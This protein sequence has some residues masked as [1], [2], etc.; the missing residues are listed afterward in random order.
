MPGPNTIYI[1]NPGLDDQIINKAT[2][3]TIEIYTRGTSGNANPQTSDLTIFAQSD[4]ASSNDVN[5]NI[6][7]YAAA[8]GSNVYLKTSSNIDFDG[9]QTFATDYNGNTTTQS[10]DGRSVFSA[11]LGGDS[12]PL[13]NPTC[14]VNENLNLPVPSDGGFSFKLPKSLVASSNTCILNLNVYNDNAATVIS[15]FYAYRIRVGT[16]DFGQ[17]ASGIT[18]GTVGANSDGD[19]A[20]DL[21]ADLL[22]IID[23][24]AILT[25]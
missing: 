12:T 3:G 19:F 17:S 13:D 23:T 24:Q 9:V 2:D 14:V 20:I 5:F 21:T 25:T 16:D 10:I 8:S 15:L 7:L 22:N 4:E 11:T 6:E 1:S 18:A